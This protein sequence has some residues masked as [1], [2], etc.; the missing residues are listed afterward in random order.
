MEWISCEKEL[1]PFNQLVIAWIDG[2]QEH[3]GLTWGREGYAFMVR[4]DDQ[5]TVANGW[6][7]SHYDEA[8]KKLGADFAFI[9][10]WHPLLPPP[11]K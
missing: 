7:L 5:H 10:H 2:R 4:H 9:T 11:N 6:S 8:I 1:P 3:S